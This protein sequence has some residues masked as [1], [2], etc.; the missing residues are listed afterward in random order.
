LGREYP[1]RTCTLFIFFKFYVAK[2]DKTIDERKTGHGPPK[3]VRQAE[4][5][6]KLKHE[7]GREKE[8][9]IVPAESLCTIALGQAPDPPEDVD[10]DEDIQA[11]YPHYY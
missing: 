1:A 8:L 6:R 10:Q 11:L 3:Q 5:A 4:Q 2:S 7:S 9:H